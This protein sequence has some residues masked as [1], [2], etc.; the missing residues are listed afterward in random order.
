MRWGVRAAEVKFSW[1]MA[2]VWAPPSERGRKLLSGLCSMGQILGWAFFIPSAHVTPTFSQPGS[3]G[4]WF[5]SEDLKEGFILPVWVL[6]VPPCSGNLGA[7]NCTVPLKCAAPGWWKLGRHGNFRNVAPFCL[8]EHTLN[9]AWWNGLC[10]AVSFFPEWF[11]MALLCEWPL[12]SFCRSS[13]VRNEHIPLFRFV[14][15]RIINFICSFLNGALKRV[16]QS[17]SRLRSSFTWWTYRQ[18]YTHWISRTQREAALHQFVLFT[19][20]SYLSSCKRWELNFWIFNSARKSC[21]NCKT[22]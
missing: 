14:S 15:L 2:Q 1:C 19:F 17:C 20:G 22:C 9:Y 7:W 11:P 16:L 4:C 10:Y 3:Q 18:L 8:S 6:H 13:S 5:S 12:C 21:F